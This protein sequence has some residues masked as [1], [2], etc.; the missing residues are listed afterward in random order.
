MVRK[1]ARLN[2]LNDKHTLQDAAIDSTNTTSYGDGATGAG[3]TNLN[4]SGKYEFVR[5]TSNVPAAGGALTFSA[6]G[7]GGG[8]LFAYTKSAATAT[9]GQRSFQVVRVPQ[10][11]SATLGYT[12]ATP[13]ATPRRGAS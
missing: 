5:A 6:S 9:Q 10:Y 11:S 3:S 13:A 2:R 8:L 1:D 4:N 12:A 7:P